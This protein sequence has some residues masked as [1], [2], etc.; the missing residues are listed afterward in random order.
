M[1]STIFKQMAHNKAESMLDHINENRSG[2]EV[3]V[4]AC[5]CEVGPLILYMAT[6]GEN[7]HVFNILDDQAN[8][9]NGMCSNWR[10]WEHIQY[11]LRHDK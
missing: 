7:N 6:N 5:C 3:Y 8:T 10:S 1:Q 9:P 2:K 11:D 4:L